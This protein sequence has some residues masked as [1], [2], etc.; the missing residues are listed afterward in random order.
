MLLSLVYTLNYCFTTIILSI[1]PAALFASIICYC[2]CSYETYVVSDAHSDYNVRTYKHQL[3]NTLGKRSVSFSNSSAD[4]SQRQN[5]CE[6][7]AE[8][9]N[10]RLN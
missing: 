5:Q 10:G 6:E 3:H 2:Q 9:S 4:K 8:E 7:R 1:S